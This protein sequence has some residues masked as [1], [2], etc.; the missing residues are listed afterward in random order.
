MKKLISTLLAAIIIASLCSFAPISHAQSDASVKQTKRISELRKQ[1]LAHR[2]KVQKQ[3]ADLRRQGKTDEADMRQKALKRR[4]EA[5]TQILLDPQNNTNDP[6]S[7]DRLMQKAR[8]LQKTSDQEFKNIDR[9]RYMAADQ[10]RKIEQLRKQGKN[11]E[12]D[13]LSAQ[14]RDLFD[15]MDPQNT[16]SVNSGMQQLRRVEQGN[17]LEQFQV[18]KVLTL[19]GQKQPKYFGGKE[20]PLIEFVLD[21]INFA[22]RLIGSFAFAVMVAGGAIMMISAGNDQLRDQG[23]SMVIYSVV[24]VIFAFSAFILTATVQAILTGS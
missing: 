22:M 13:Q 14:S 20:A 11:K 1:E 18:T 8:N 15:R 10:Q 24:G 12:S 17:E 7:I 21:I 4:T 2:A 6:A 9:I 23:K 16:S 3:I 19:E 5:M